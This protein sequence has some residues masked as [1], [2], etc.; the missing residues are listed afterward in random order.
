MFALRVSQYDLDMVIRWDDS[1]DPD[2]PLITGDEV[3]VFKVMVRMK[4]EEVGVIGMQPWAGDE[5]RTNGFAFHLLCKRIFDDVEVIEGELPT[6]H[7]PEVPE[8]A[9]P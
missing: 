3:A 6:I 1:I 5:L 7:I 2:D 9:T 8:G 4:V